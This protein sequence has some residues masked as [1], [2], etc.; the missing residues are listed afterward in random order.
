VPINTSVCYCFNFEAIFYAVENTHIQQQQSILLQFTHACLILVVNG[1][2][3]MNNEITITWVALESVAHGGI[4][5]IATDD[6]I[7]WIPE[8][9][10]WFE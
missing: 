2:K 4:S 10:I 3:L 1:T 8:H 5:V 7:A 6:Y 9:L